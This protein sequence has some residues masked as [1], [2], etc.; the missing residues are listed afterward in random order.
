M[1]SDISTGNINI[2]FKVREGRF[3]EFFDVSI[4]KVFNE[5][6]LRTFEN[7]SRLSNATKIAYE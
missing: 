5:C 6:I 7:E 4:S 1:K 3:G 2:K